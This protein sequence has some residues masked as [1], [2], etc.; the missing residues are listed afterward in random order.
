MYTYFCMHMNRQFTVF[1]LTYKFKFVFLSFKSKTNSGVFLVIQRFRCHFSIFQLNARS[2][3]TARGHPKNDINQGVGRGVRGSQKPDAD[4]IFGW[5]LMFF[6]L[7]PTGFTRTASSVFIVKFDT[8]QIVH[9]A[10]R[11]QFLSSSQI[12]SSSPLIGPLS[13]DLLKKPV[14]GKAYRP[15][16][17]MAW[18]WHLPFQKHWQCCPLSNF[19]PVLRLNR[20][21]RGPSGKAQCLCCTFVRSTG[22]SSPSPQTQNRCPSVFSLPSED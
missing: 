16:P 18:E 12:H 5:P 20:S 9:I 15:K 13:S 14:N 7:D 8:V 10:N 17:S 21:A 6:T 1:C 19:E 2:T 3:L 4:V 22:L 11:E